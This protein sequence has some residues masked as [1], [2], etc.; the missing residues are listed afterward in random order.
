MYINALSF[1]TPSNIYNCLALSNVPL[2][3]LLVTQ[4]EHNSSGNRCGWEEEGYWMQE[5][6]TKVQKKGRQHWMFQ[7]LLI[8][9]A[10]SAHDQRRSL[11]STYCGF[12]L[13][14]IIPCIIFLFSY[15]FTCICNGISCS[16]ARAFKSATLSSK[17]SSMCSLFSTSSY[18]SKCKTMK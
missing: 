18:E 9:Y 5:D 7:C 14:W 17:T 6:W 13:W 15:T 11:G 12:N 8:L 2:K 1:C 16:L 3:L 10:K 4:Q